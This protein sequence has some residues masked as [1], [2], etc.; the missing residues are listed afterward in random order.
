MLNDIEKIKSK[1]KYWKKGEHVFLNLYNF[2]LILDSG[3]NVEIKEHI[4]ESK[5][6]EGQC[7]IDLPINSNQAATYFEWKLRVAKIGYKKEKYTRKTFDPHRRTYHNVED[8]MKV[9]N[10]INF[11]I[12]NS[13]RFVLISSKSGHLTGNWNLNAEYKNFALKESD[14][15]LF[16]FDCTTGTLFLRKN[17][18]SRILL[19][20]VDN[21]EKLKTDPFYPW[22]KFERKGDKIEILSAGPLHNSIHSTPKVVSKSA[23]YN[24][25]TVWFMIVAVCI[26]CYSK[27]IYRK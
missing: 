23:N 27:Y 10:E 7:F 19:G 24:Q 8:T 3:K 22:V 15:L 2:H 1:P 14:I 26:A 21:L 6:K 5:D 11:G 25:A 16:Q 9:E 18:E 13:N 12:K 17:D 4:L 20:Y